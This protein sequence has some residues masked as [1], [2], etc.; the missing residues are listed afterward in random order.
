MLM[1]ALS[2]LNDH[3][4]FIEDRIK[5]NFFLKRY[6]DL[7]YDIDPEQVSV[8]R[9]IRVNTLKISEEDLLAR[10][11]KK[12]SLRKIP[13]T[14]TGYWVDADFSLSSTPE[15]LQGYYYIQEAASQLPAQVLGPGKGGSVLDMCAAPGSKTTQLAQLMCNQGSIIALDSHSCRIGALNNN[16]E[17]CGVRN[18]IAYHKDAAHADDL[19]MKFDRILLD[20]PCSGNFA[21]DPGWFSRRDLEGIRQ[22]AKVQKTLLKTAAGLLNKDGRLVYST[23][24]LEPEE[25]EEVVEWALDNLPL[26]L[27]DTGLSIG[28]PG[29]TDSTCL[30]RRFW[31]GKHDTQGF[32]IAKMRLRA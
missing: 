20:A 2:L 15:Y 29:S 25:D 7:G 18:C 1:R 11:K 3:E 5:M 21:T 32:F 12:V 13:F 8:A 23:C 22:N 4:F 17:R 6:S 27:E 14:G 28:E 16:L 10:L 31:P 30:C 9:A 19:D 24:S 26:E